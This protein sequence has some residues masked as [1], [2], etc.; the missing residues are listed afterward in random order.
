MADDKIAEVREEQ[1]ILEDLINSKGW[2][3]VKARLIENYKSARKTLC[4]YPSAEKQDEKNDIYGKGQL[5]GFLTAMNL[6]EQM[7]KELK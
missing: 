2:Q 4:V 3:K 1:E 5:D 6:P 7:L